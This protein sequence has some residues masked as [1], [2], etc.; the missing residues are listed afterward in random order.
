MP[1]EVFHGAGIDGHKETA[2]VAIRHQGPD[3]LTPNRQETRTF[4]TLTDNLHALHLLSP[5]GPGSTKRKA[6]RSLEGLGYQVTLVSR[7]S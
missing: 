3:Q 5:K 2:V 4:G 1:V 7:V 6:L